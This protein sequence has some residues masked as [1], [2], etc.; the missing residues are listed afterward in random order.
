MKT[1]DIQ[2]L[3]S[4]LLARKVM[5]KQKKDTFAQKIWKIRFWN[6]SFIQ[7]V[8][9]QVAN[10]LNKSRLCFLRK[11]ILLNHKLFIISCRHTRIVFFGTLVEFWSLI[12]D[13]CVAFQRNFLSYSC[14]TDAWDPHNLFVIT[15]FRC[16]CKVLFINVI[17]MYLHY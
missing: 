7:T 10:G 15:V 12:L 14:K 1:R 2:I 5:I 8:I 11:K 9:P 4:F 13:S 16:N 6:L 3:P 17:N